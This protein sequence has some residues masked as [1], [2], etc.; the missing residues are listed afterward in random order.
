M[1]I[2]ELFANETSSKIIGEWKVFFHQLEN[3]R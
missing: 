2:Y 1:F 3:F